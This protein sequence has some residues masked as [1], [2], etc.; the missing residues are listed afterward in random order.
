MAARTTGTVFEL[1]KSG[2][3][4]T[5]HPLFL[6]WRQHRRCQPLCR[7]DRGRQ[8]Q[9]LRHHVNGGANGS[10]TVFELVKNGS[11]YHPTILYSFAG[12]TRRGQPLCRPDRGRQRQSL[13][14]HGSGRRERLRHGLRAGQER[15]QL[16]APTIL[17][18]FAGGTDGAIPN[19]GLIADGSGDLFGTTNQGGPGSTARSSSWSR[20]AAA[21]P[22]PSSIPS[23][24]APPTGRTPMAGL[25]AD[26]NGNLFGTTHGGGTSN[27]GTVFELVKS[28]SAATPTPSS[29]P[30][31]AAHRR[32]LPRCRP[33]RGRQRQSL[34]HHGAARPA[35]NGAG[36]VFELVKSGSSYT[37]NVLHF[38]AGGTS[39]GTLPA[40]DLIADANGNIFGTTMEGGAGFGTV[41]ETS[42]LL[43]RRP[44]PA[45]TRLSA[46]RPAAPALPLPAPTW[47]APRQ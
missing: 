20:A 2:S 37:E 14:H 44:S 3:S 28:G 21:T 32:G 27:V 46:I 39:D 24:A 43:P 45:S 5:D 41:F 29:I 33:D 8:R 9:S 12:G 4:Y 38:F 23:P 19:A 16:H 13:R 18:S 7:P 40:S 34:R 25:I 15:Q 11:S 42:G 26:G 22:R 30:S 35:P 1:V 47:P 17:Y 10:G 6:Y 36:M 31:P